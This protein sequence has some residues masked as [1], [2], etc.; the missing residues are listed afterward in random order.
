M[1]TERILNNEFAMDVRQRGVR[2]NDEWMLD[3]F[4]DRKK[5]FKLN[6][7]RYEITNGPLFEFDQLKSKLVFPHARNV[8]WHYE[9]VLVSESHHG[10]NENSRYLIRSLGMMP[11]KLNGMFCFEAFLE[12][13][14][15]VDIGYNRIHFIKPKTSLSLV[16]DNSKINSEVMKSTMPILLEGETGSGKTTMAKNI[17]DESGRSGRFVHLNLSAFAPS[18]VESEIFGHVKGAFTGALNPKRGAI[19]EAHKGTL[20][21]DEIDSLTLDLQTKLLLFLDDY[22]VRA[23]GGEHSTKVDVR[24]I[25]ASGSKLKDLVAEGKMRK[26]FFYR[27]HSGCTYS[28]P[29][30][31][32]Q[33]ALIKDLLRTFEQ[34]QAVVF[35]QELFEFYSQ[36]KWPGNIRQLHSHLMKKKIYSGGKKIILDDTDKELLT[37]VGETKLLRGS[38]LIPL[39]KVKTDYCYNVWVKFDK[40]TCRTAKVLEVSPNTLKVYLNRKQLELKGEL[41]DDEII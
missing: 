15:V 4:Q 33:P 10:H 1:Q 17:H 5:Q 41:R 30:L 20:F 6:R 8:G 35:D 25:F 31:R 28:L 36:C 27:L 19:V 18:L 2:E 7:T 23:V 22:H 40:N 32:D 13:G 37:D 9:I 11:F 24:L 12:R 34:T 3:I 26:D 21:L 14:D 29:P 39:E 38:D 16:P